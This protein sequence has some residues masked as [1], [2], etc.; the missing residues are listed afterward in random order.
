MSISAISAI[1]F[2][3]SPEVT[4]KRR[5]INLVRSMRGLAVNFFRETQAA[6][7]HEVSA[8]NVANR[9]LNSQQH[10]AALDAFKWEFGNF[11]SWNGLVNEHNKQQHAY[12]VKTTTNTIV[13][14]IMNAQVSGVQLTPEQLSIYAR[15]GIRFWHNEFKQEASRIADVLARYYEL[16]Q[17]AQ[18]STD[19]Q[20]PAIKLS[21]K[22]SH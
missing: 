13:T 7:N 4:A 19:R 15:A 16:T 18:E 14:K 2:K 12:W 10:R 22:L 1:P 9:A 8:G 6:L 3:H 20:Y 21:P 11:Q 17:Q 5:Q